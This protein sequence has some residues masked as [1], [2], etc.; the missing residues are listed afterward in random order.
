MAMRKKL[1]IILLVL[2]LT[3]IAVSDGYRSQTVETIET[4]V[5]FLEA[6]QPGSYE[7]TEVNDGDT[8][9]VLMNGKQEVVRLIGI[10]TPELHHPEK[11][12]QC[13]AGAARHFTA[14]LIG[15]SN[16]RLEA[17][18]EDDNRDIYGRL[19]RYAYL[20][21]GTLI[22]AEGVEQ[23]YGF[24]YTRFPFTKLEE[25]R[26]LEADARTNQ[27]GLWSGCTIQ[28]EDGVMETNSVQ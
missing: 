8:I 25:F 20:E 13:F 2:L 7:V 24:A 18:P 27:R 17:D 26:A 11:P 14:D 12:V 21:D 10:D 4:I 22:N 28:E 9:T 16:V 23:G 1:L 6:N 15:D 3:P 5:P 19:L